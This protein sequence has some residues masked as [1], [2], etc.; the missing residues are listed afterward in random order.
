MPSFFGKQSYASIVSE[1]KKEEE[2]EDVETCFFP[3]LP[4]RSAMLAVNSDS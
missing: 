1:Q 3:L 2:G 4:P